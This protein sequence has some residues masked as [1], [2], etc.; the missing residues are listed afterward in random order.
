MENKYNQGESYI[1][2]KKQKDFF[3][4]RL[5]RTQLT[6]CFHGSRVPVGLSSSRPQSDTPE[7]PPHL[8]SWTTNEN[9]LLP[10]LVTI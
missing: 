2:L 4:S 8:T 6:A 7:L 9:L 3:V 10:Q 5:R 1:V